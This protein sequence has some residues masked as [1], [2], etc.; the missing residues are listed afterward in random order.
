MVNMDPFVKAQL[1]KLVSTKLCSSTVGQCAMSIVTNEPKP[2]E[3]SYELFI[4][5]KTQVLD[6]LKKKAQLVAEVFNSIPGISCQPVMG[7]MYTF[8][9]IQ[10]PPKAIEA[11]KADGKSPDAFYCFALL[12]ETGLC[13]VPGSG[14]GQRPG[15]YHFRMTIL[16]PFEAIAKNMALFKEFHSNFM[17][18]YA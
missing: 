9:S 8:P 14:F 4:Q 5:E 16:P 18:K 11:A 17:E 6:I 10:L 12:E 3:P 15:T 1:V 13:V 2:G 7:A